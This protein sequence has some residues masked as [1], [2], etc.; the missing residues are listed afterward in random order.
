MTRPALVLLL[1]TAT[2]AHAD[3]ICSPANKLVLV[4]RIWCGHPLT[5][6]TGVYDTSSGCWRDAKDTHTEDHCQDTKEGPRLDDKH[7]PSWDAAGLRTCAE[8][9]KNLKGCVC[10]S[11]WVEPDE[12][13]EKTENPHGFPVA[14]GFCTVDVQRA[15]PYPPG[16]D[17]FISYGTHVEYLG[18]EEQKFAFRK[19]MSDKGY[20]LGQPKRK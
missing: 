2:S 16:F 4:W 13:S 18:S 7:V 11:E 8:V 12:P 6:R 1:L 14:V 19:C 15:F 9:R 17:A 10:Q 20:P 3:Q 5:A